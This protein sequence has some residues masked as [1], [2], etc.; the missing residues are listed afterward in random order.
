MELSQKKDILI[1]IRVRAS[2]LWEDVEQILVDLQDLS[3]NL[4]AGA[5]NSWCIKYIKIFECLQ[6]SAMGWEKTFLEETQEGQ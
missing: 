4:Q 5:L 2:K 1:C 6:T 3:K